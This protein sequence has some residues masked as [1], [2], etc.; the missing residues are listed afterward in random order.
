VADPS[1]VPRPDIELLL[2]MNHNVRIVLECKRLLR[3]SATARQYVVQGVQRFVE[4]RY[5]TDEGTGWMIGFLLDRDI[6]TAAAEIGGVLCPVSLEGPEA[7]ER[8]I[9]R[10]LSRHGA[11]LK[12]R[13]ILIDA[14]SRAAFPVTI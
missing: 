8:D 2:G 14:R 1:R 11:S 7:G 6:A 12:I 5:C 9:G 4:G 10:F 13:H 3:G